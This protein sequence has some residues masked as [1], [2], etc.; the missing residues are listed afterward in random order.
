MCFEFST[1][2][3]IR[4]WKKVDHKNESDLIFNTGFSIENSETCLEEIRQILQASEISLKSY[5]SGQASLDIFRI[6]YR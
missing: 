5:L 6:G 4:T 1:G 2:K 3:I